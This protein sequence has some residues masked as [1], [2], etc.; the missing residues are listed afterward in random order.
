MYGVF[1]PS[2]K[3]L[4]DKKGM[5]SVCFSWDVHAEHVGSP[6]ECGSDSQQDA[7]EATQVGA[8]LP[9]GRRR[10]AAQGRGGFLEPLGLWEPRFMFSH[11]HP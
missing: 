9:C 3:Q 2:A 4:I 5:G 7:S 8:R 11:P 6:R 1:P 10:P